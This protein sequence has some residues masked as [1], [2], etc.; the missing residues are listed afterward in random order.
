VL[1]ASLERA[2]HGRNTGCLA[3]RQRKALKS[4]RLGKLSAV[5]LLHLI[6]QDD[7]G[8]TEDPL[9]GVAKLPASDRASTLG[10]VLMQLQQAW[11]YSA[12]KHSGEI[13]QFVTALTHKIVEGEKAGMA[14]SDLSIFYARLMRRVCQKSDGFAGR[15][16]VATEAPDRQWV[17]DTAFE[18]VSEFQSK[19]TVA[20]CTKACAGMFEPVSVP[21]QSR[22]VGGEQDEKPDG[23]GGPKQQKKQK[24][25][26]AKK[27]GEREDNAKAQD[28]DKDDKGDDDGPSEQPGTKRKKVQKELNDKLGKRGDKWPCFFHHHLKKCNFS[29]D[30][31]R[32]YH[33]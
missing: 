22:K 7:A 27:G 1:D 30:D 21:N 24:K 17:K 13:M 29:A 26:K 16:A 9:K 3:E 19:F 12:P 18:W 23:K 11:I 6:D 20:R 25:R 10:E 14:W 2:V 8:T 28:P 33:D 5:R 32:N 31:C 15:V 4:I